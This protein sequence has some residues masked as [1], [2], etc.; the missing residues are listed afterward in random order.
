MS[1]EVIDLTRVDDDAGAAAGGGDA[2]ASAARRAA[3]R[4]RRR[5][6]AA[7]AGAEVI[8]LSRDECAGAAGSG[9]SGRVRAPFA[10]GICL[11]DCAAADG[12]ALFCGHVYCR[13]CL[14]AHCA[15]QVGDGLPDAG[16]V[17]CPEP[18]CRA[19]LTGAD[20]A[21]V[22]DAPTAARFE[23]LALEQ[24]VQKNRDSMGCCPTPGCSYL[25]AWDPA[26]RKLVCPL[27]SKAYCV[28][29][30]VRRLASSRLAMAH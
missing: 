11:S 19:P 29:C 6:A 17:P 22:A 23:A 27:C 1:R 30:Q 8:D 18:K 13:D 14:G 15:S 24:L 21:A 20:V 5:A 12:H 26:N 28:H 9:R 2:D 16:G 3:K 10:C 4:A 7:S 25:F